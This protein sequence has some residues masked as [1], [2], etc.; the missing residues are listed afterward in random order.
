MA[1]SLT[2]ALKNN[3]KLLNPL[4]LTEFRVKSPPSTQFLSDW[5]LPVGGNANN[6][7]KAMLQ[8]LAENREAP[9]SRS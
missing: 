6:P 2:K 8:R 3:L 9:L 7:L 1:K 4:Q 5:H